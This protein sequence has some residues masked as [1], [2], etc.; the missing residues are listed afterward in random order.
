[1]VVSEESWSEASTVVDCFQRFQLKVYCPMPSEVDSR[2]AEV[3][4][5]IYECYHPDFQ[6]PCFTDFIV[7]V[8]EVVLQLVGEEE[9]GI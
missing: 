6:G 8:D 2:L 3:Q 9:Q 1:M 5:Q 7:S 4:S